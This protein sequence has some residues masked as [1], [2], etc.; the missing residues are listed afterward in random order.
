MKQFLRTILRILD[1]S[2]S[3]SKA[4][5]NRQRGQSMLELALITPLLATLVAG[6]VEVGW[7]TNHWLT[8]LEVTRVGARFGTSL[9]DSLSPLEWID[10]ASV[11]PAI[12]TEFMEG[13][14]DDESYKR[15]ENARACASSGFYSA[16][17]CLTQSSLEPLVL[18]IDLIDPL[19]A[20]EDESGEAD[21]VS[22]DDIV[23]SV[24]SIQTVNNAE[25]NG[26][27]DNNEGVVNGRPRYYEWDTSGA[28][29]EPN[30]SATTALYK[31]SYDLNQF[32][33]HRNYPPGLQNI[34]IGRYPST[35]NECTHK[36]TY[37]SR[38]TDGF[39]GFVYPNDLTLLAATDPGFETDPFDYLSN[40]N[41]DIT[42]IS[43]YRL[44]AGEDYPLELTDASGGSLADT[45]N[46]FQRGYSFT[47]QHRIDDPNV[48]CYGSEFS[49]A[50][51]ETLV[52]MP[53][54]IQPDILHPP[55]NPYNYAL[56]SS[57]Y[58]EWLVSDEYHAW[59][60][61]DAYHDW[62]DIPAGKQW[63]DDEVYGTQD[64]RAFFRSQGMTLVEVFWEHDMLLNFGF[65]RPLKEAYGD[66]DIVIALWSAFP[67]P[68]VSPSIIYQLP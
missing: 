66:G 38:E 27:E 42:G 43:T 33:D 9:T 34:V 23:V 55:Y 57:Q 36:G 14:V 13:T 7:Y 51:V 19:D 18:A 28:E 21:P 48:F 25:E 62:L 3:T 45:G 22:H 50:D 54:F 60:N 49:I 53:G 4:T 17:S 29:I 11:F 59:H 63:V 47:G 52:N 6:A 32:A 15:A 8:L 24:F 2:P 31:I 35:A 64:E 10:D 40:D 46:E 30:V 12:Q 26:R 41:S 5:R 58:Q 1:G 16:I 37:K 56:G 39:G 44:W 61:S 20:S 68:S 67:L 65:F